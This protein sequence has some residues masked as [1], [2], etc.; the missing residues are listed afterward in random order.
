MK[1]YLCLCGLLMLLALPESRC[2]AATN[3]ALGTT[4]PQGQPPAS[5]NPTEVQK[6]GS[7]SEAPDHSNWE[8]GKSGIIVAGVLVSLNLTA[9]AMLVCLWRKWGGTSDVIG[10]LTTDIA[11][12]NAQY[13]SLQAEFKKVADERGSYTDAKQKLDSLKRDI[14]DLRNLFATETR[15][16]LTEN[17]FKMEVADL[18]QKIAGGTK[19]PCVISPNAQNA[20]NELGQMSGRISKMDAAVAAIEQRLKQMEKVVYALDSAGQQMT[21]AA[22]GFNASVSQ[23]EGELVAIQAKVNSVVAAWS[24][25]LSNLESTLNRQTAAV[26]QAQADAHQREH[27]ATGRLGQAQQM[28]AE[29]AKERESL[30]LKLREA[31]GVLKIKEDAIAKESG[32]RQ[33][34]LRCLAEIKQERQEAQAERLAAVQDRAKAESDRQKAAADG[35]IAEA[36]RSQAEAKLQEAA[37]KGFFRDHSG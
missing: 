37:R 35:K 28:Q 26:E 34:N 15:A 20:I 7:P 23:S 24:E 25:K 36:A 29:V 2:T 3:P 18:I 1:A 32:L 19:A 21:Q 5:G 9:L 12:I 14:A 16:L 10:G 13:S 6:P 22:S 31:A 8:R 30:E 4:Q 27:E 17:R 33:E 11:G